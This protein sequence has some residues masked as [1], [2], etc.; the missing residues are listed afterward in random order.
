MHAH[1]RCTCTQ[2]LRNVGYVVLYYMPLEVFP[3]K[4]HMHVWSGRHTRMEYILTFCCLLD[5]LLFDFRFMYW[6]IEAVS[7]TWQALL[8]YAVISAR[9]TTFVMA[10]RLMW[11]RVLR[12]HGIEKYVALNIQHSALHFPNTR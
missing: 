8:E 7:F 10:G 11:R 9:P 1:H 2:Y 6:L 3:E 4:P 12:Q 5:T